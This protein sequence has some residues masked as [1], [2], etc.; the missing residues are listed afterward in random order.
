MPVPDA[1]NGFL[2]SGV[3]IDPAS[4]AKDFGSRSLRRQTGRKHSR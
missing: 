3:W 4:R 1:E 2:V